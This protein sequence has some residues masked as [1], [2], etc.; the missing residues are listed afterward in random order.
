[1]ILFSQGSALLGYRANGVTFML[2]IDN[3]ELRAWFQDDTPTGLYKRIL[4]AWLPP[5]VRAR[6]E[7]IRPNLERRYDPART[8]DYEPPRD[9]EGRLL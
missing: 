6:V 5:E 9:A 1:M 2:A 7:A 4:S 8:S 3:G